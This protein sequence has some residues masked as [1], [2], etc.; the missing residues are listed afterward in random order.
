MKVANDSRRNPSG[1]EGGVA[2]LGLSDLIQL[3]AANRFSGSFR[4]RHDD[5]IGVIFFRDGEVVH[6][7]MGGKIGEEAFCDILEWQRGSFDAEPNVVAARRTIQKSC[8]H[9]L[10]DAHRMIDERRAQ[11]KSSAPSFPE[12]A[13]SPA[14]KTSITELVRAI[15]DVSGAVVL[16]SDGK[17]LGTGGYQDEALA[18]QVAYLALFGSEF[19]TLFQAGDL[20][21]AMVDASQH[22]LL[23]YSNRSHYLGVSCQPESDPVAVDAAIRNVLNKGR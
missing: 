16:T 8:Q 7:E 21:S 11:S 22:H 19:G 3:S 23:L 13:A 18:G 1:F 9:L 4:V 15:P 6:A 17:R 20:R 10:L 5:Q 2:G 14:A 12:P